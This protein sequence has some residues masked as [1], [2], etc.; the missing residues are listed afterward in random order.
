MKKNIF[1]TN[2]IFGTNLLV[3]SSVVVPVNEIM[4]PW[5]THQVAVQ[6]DELLGSNCKDS[7]Q[8]INIISLFFK[9]NLSL[10]RFTA[11]YTSSLLT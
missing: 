6:T 11:T 7:S 10:S 4:I 3:F 5:A 9:L 8:N 1:Y 2:A